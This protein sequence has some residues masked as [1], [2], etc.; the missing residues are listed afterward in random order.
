MTEALT[1]VARAIRDDMPTY[2]HPDLYKTVMDIVGFTEESLMASL[3][4]L[5]DNKAH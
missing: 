2:M 1:N 4:C 3:G 5:V